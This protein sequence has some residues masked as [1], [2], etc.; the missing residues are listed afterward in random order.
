MIFDIDGD[1]S[2]L[3]GGFGLTGTQELSGYDTN[4]DGKITAADAIWSDLRVW[5]DKDEDGVTDAG[6]LFTLDAAGISGIG[7]SGLA[8]LEMVANDNAEVLRAVA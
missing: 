8:Q 1:G 2:E 7:L 4:T 5:Q 3:F 6:E